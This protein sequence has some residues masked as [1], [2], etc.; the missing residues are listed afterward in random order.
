MSAKIPRSEYP[1]PQFVRENWINLNGT[2]TYEFDFGKSGRDREIWKGNTGFKNKI[3]VPFCPESDLSGVGH[4]DFIEAMF[5]HKKLAI[6]ADWKGKRILLHFGGVDYSC[7]AFIDGK[8]T[9]LIHYGG[10]S[11]FTFDITEFVKA[12]GKH[13]LVLAIEDD[14]RSAVQ[15]HGKQCYLYQSMGCFYTRTTG[16]W[17]T[18]WME[19]VAMD[20]LKNCKIV[21]DLD[22]KAFHFTPEFFMEGQNRTLRVT[23]KANGKKVAEKSV[24]ANSAMP[25]TVELGKTVRAWCPEDPFL[26]DIAYELIDANGVVVD[27]VSAYAGL[28]KVHTENGKVYLNN[29]PIFLRLVLDQGFY[30]DGIW[31][32]PTDEALKKDIEL[33]MAAGFN[34]ARLHQKVF[35]VFSRKAGDKVT[36]SGPYGEFFLPDNLPDTQELIFIGGGAGMAPMRS[37]IMHLFKTEKTKRPVSFW[38]GARALKEAPYMEDFRGIEKDFPNFKFNLALDRPDPEAD[39]AGEKYTA[40]FVHNVLF[41]N[42]L[43]NH[44]E[45]ESCIYLMC[46]PPMM[47]ASV[48]KMLDSLGVPKENIL[49]DNFGA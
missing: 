17:Q 44:E 12:G 39:A 25:F 35:D 7:E 37:H 11:S 6:P 42:Y 4:K 48:E 9:G 8:E 5:Y 45:P 1:R 33:S 40:G 26:Y 19:P 38:Y 27:T 47:V 10:T 29:K 15:P 18:V 31:T 14:Q 20:G 34:G 24:P 13:D 2:W 49:Y 30:P 41:E 21:P 28:R 32:A 22:A 23:I 36:I 3:T 46:G 43:K 16:I